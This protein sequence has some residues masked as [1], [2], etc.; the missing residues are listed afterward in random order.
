VAKSFSPPAEPPRTPNFTRRALIMVGI[1][2]AVVLLLA[3]VWYI[4][5]VLLLVFAGVL[6]AIFLRALA[7]WLRDRSG[8]RDGWAL[9]L[10]CVALLAL[11]G[12]GGWLLAPSVIEQTT[13]LVERVPQSLDRVRATIEQY[14][15]GRLLLQ[16]TPNAENLPSGDIVGQIAGI[17]STTIGGIA[18]IVIVLFVGLYLAVEPGMYVNG[19]VRLVPPAK[20][21]RAR[22]VLEVL[23]YTLRRWLVGRFFLMIVIGV[24]TTIGL[25]LLGVPLALTLGIIAALLTFIPNIGPLLSVIPAALLALSQGPQFALYVLLLYAGIQTV[26]S[27][28]LEPIVEH[29]ATYL[30][31]VLVI[32]SQV[33]LGISQGVIGLL[34]AT[35]LFAVTAVLVKMLYVEDVLRDRTLDV[36]GEPEAQRAVAMQHES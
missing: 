35:P 3:L 36:Q 7:D 17:F 11:F 16:Q 26:E 22:E 31:P 18:N 14:E 2:T 5:E 13:Q 9:A 4:F 34:L 12:G 21:D 6:L 15:L 19:L 25:L 1:V 23:G 20:R 29:R 10:V 8:M 24:L 30:P 32:L 33:V 27:Y 28:V